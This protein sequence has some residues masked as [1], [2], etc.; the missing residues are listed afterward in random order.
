[1]KRKILYFLCTGNS[2]RSQMAEGFAKKYLGFDA[3]EVRSAGIEQHGLNPLATEVM[4][5]VG[6]DISNQRSNLIDTSLMNNAEY[7]I[8]LCDDARARCPSTPPEVNSLHWG[9]EDPAAVQGTKE[10]KL[11]AF[12]RVRDQIDTRIQEFVEMQNK[13]GN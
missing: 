9:F 11:V 10:E 5:E 1:M 4:A 3:W 6:V 7:V 8:T 2:A 12:R 13:A